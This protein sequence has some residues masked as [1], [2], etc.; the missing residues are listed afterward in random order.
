[1][2]IRRKARDPLAR[3][4]GLRPSTPRPWDP[5]QSQFPAI[6]PISTLL[7]GQ[8]DLGAIAI[9]SMSAYTNGFGFVVTRLV[10]PG[11]PGWDQ[12][13]FTAQSLFEVSLRFSDGRT[14]STGRPA[15]GAEPAGPFL[16]MQG[17][18]GSSHVNQMR[19]W[20]WPL[21]PS[22][23]LEFSCQWP[24]MG[25]SEARASIEAELILDAARRAVPVWPEH[26]V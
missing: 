5:P 13:P 19:C 22:G 20:A 10:R 8:S 24:A 12:E 11:T 15:G 14:V 21:P 17:G 16:R 7:L 25:I 2:R 18:G 3:R 4:P 23:P 1:M 26:Q 6:V 9:T